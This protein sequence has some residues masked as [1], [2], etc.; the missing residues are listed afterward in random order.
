VHAEVTCRNATVNGLSFLHNSAAGQRFVGE[1]SFEVSLERV[2]YTWRLQRDDGTYI[3]SVGRPV[4][5]HVMPAGCDLLEYALNRAIE[6]IRRYRVN[7]R[8]VFRV[9]NWSW[10]Q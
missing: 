9:E 4:S 5:L 8:K 2:Y 7:R 10:K 3:G 1:I 6:G